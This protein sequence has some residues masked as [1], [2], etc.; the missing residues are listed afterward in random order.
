MVQLD[1]ITTHIISE[2]QKEA[3]RIDEEA[4]RKAEDILAQAKKDAEQ[5]YE[6][7]VSEGEKQAFKVLEIAEAAAV[8][9]RTMAFLSSKVEYIEKTIAHAKNM[10]LSMPYERYE[11]YLLGLLDLYAHKGQTGTIV[12]GLRDFSRLGE[13][14]K[15]KIKQF[16]LTAESS[17]RPLDAGFILKYGDIEENCSLE[18]LIR[19]K[20]EKLMDIISQRLF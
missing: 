16:D 9:E 1:R 19:N 20:K 6:A 7:I 8:H 2:A 18:A 13:A 3:E 14:L 15:E 10:I 5:A 17:E 11:M 4:K 12:F